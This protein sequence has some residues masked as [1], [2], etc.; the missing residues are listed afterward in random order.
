MKKKLLFDHLQATLKRSLW[1]TIMLVLATQ[2]SLFAQTV[3]VKGTVKSG[4]GYTLPGVSVV[5]KGT[6]G[7]TITGADGKYSLSAQSGGTLIFSFVGF[8]TQEL[9]IGGKTQ[10]D[11]TLT[12]SAT[13]LSEVVVMG[14]GNQKKKDV[15]GA[16]A[17]VS[18]KEFVERPNTQF[19]YA[20]EGKVA[21]V[22]I[23]RPSGQP[24]AGFSIRVRGT[25]TITAGSEPL[26]IVDGVPTT[27]I[28]EIN[29]ADIESMTILKD[30]SAAS[31]YGAS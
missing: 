15:T 23:V 13:T 2:M 18:S 4:D 28:N 11:V 17:T 5:I 27:S 16:V 8:E 26:Y 31:I 7:G 12:E 6:T 3:T 10:I 19:G 24:Q 22:E 30:A 25:S 9:F 20:L 21:G 1:L 14:Y 29:P